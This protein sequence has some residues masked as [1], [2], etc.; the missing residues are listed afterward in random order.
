MSS[1]HSYDEGFAYL[2]NQEFEK[3]EKFFA[4][5]LAYRPSNKTALICHA[6][7]VGL[8]GDSKRALQLMQDL[9]A[10][11]SDDYEVGLNYSEALMWNG[12]YEEAKIEYQK[13]I[14]IDSTNFVANYGFANANSALEEYDLAIEYNQRAIDIDSTNASAKNARMYILLGNAYSLMQR[15]QFEKSEM[16]IDTITKYYPTNPNAIEILEQINSKKTSHIALNYYQ[17]SDGIGNEAQGLVASSQAYVSPRLDAIV[18]FHDRTATLRGTPMNTKQ[19]IVDVGGIYHASKKIDIKAG[20]GVNAINDKF[21]NVKNSNLISNVSLRYQIGSRQFAELKYNSEAYNYSVPILSEQILLNHYSIVHHIS[22]PSSIGN[23]SNA[24]LTK[25]TDGNQRLLIFNS[26]Y[27][28]FGKHPLKVG[29]NYTLI[30]N[31]FRRDELYFSP[32][33][34]RSVETFLMFENSAKKQK[35]QYNINGAIGLQKD[36]KLENLVTKRVELT[37]KYPIT[38][39]L[40]LGIKYLAGNITEGFNSGS[41]TFNQVGITLVYKL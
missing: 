6:R 33:S 38:N 40:I 26:L 5:A 37:A 2:E 35:F 3:A 32:L 27:Y 13:L 4:D 41:Y 30:R 39:H 9:R 10:D 18:S 24:I 36:G 21:E 15:R 8:K 1:Q 23:Y 19:R 34:F 14:N 25:Q 16:W 31:K 12:K 28:D 20:V 7:A 29:L 11:F 22:F 17:S